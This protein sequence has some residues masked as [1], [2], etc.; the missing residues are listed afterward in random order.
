SLF[1]GVVILATSVVGQFT[2]KLYEH[3]SRK[4][5]NNNF[6]ASAFCVKIGMSMILMGAEGKTADELRRALILPEDK[7]EVAKIYDQLMTNL[8]KRK[9]VAILDMA[10]R[11]FVNGSYGINSNY[12]KLVKKSFR[13][14]V[15]AINLSDRAKAAWTISDWVLD[16]TLDNVKGTISPSNLAADESAVLVNAAFFKG[17][18]KTRF[19]RKSTKVKTFHISDKQTVLVPMMTQVGIFKMR[20]SAYD[21]IIEMPFAYSNLSMVIVLPHS[22]ALLKR[23][24][25]T[26]DSFSETLDEIQ[27]HVQLPRFKIEFGTELVDTLKDMGIIDLFS[28]SSDLSGLLK[29]KGTRISQV[30]H[31]AFVE[32]NED[33]ASA[34][35]A[36]AVMVRGVSDFPEKVSS[37]TAD[38]PFVFIIRDQS[39]IYFRGRVVDPLKNSTISI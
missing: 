1:E 36:S 19:Q 23:A 37:F 39:T 8:E 38:R 22:N 17:Y 25:S 30:I 31:K 24:E 28:N 16:K 14:E 26:I 13:A 18:W 12:N 35:G 5:G 15:E 33:G 34:G 9:K 29:G 7:M 21:R 11:L 2:D 3:L 4:P 10:N 32:I 6:I 20:S 27:V